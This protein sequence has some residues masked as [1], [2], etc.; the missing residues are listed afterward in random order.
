[1]GVEQRNFSSDDALYVGPR[2]GCCSALH[3]AEVT[4]SSKQAAAAMLMRWRL[5]RLRLLLRVVSAR[6][7]DYAVAEFCPKIGS[8]AGLQWC[9]FHVSLWGRVEA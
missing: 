9:R 4:I 3:S 7:H 6:L 5:V 2:R 1:M 8:T